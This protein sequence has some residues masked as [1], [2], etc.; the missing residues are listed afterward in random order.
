MLLNGEMTDQFFSRLVLGDKK[1]GAG[2]SKPAL[3]LT[4]AASF[5]CAL[6]ASY[7]IYHVYLLKDMEIPA[8]NKDSIMKKVQEYQL[9]LRTG[10][11][12]FLKEGYTKIADVTAAP[13]DLSQP[14]VVVSEFKPPIDF[15]SKPELLLEPEKLE[16]EP[17]KRKRDKRELITPVLTGNHTIVFRDVGESDASKIRVLAE[18][19]DLKLNII[20]STKKSSRKW[21]VYKENPASKKIVAGKK[22]SFIKSFNKRNDA[23]KYLQNNKIAGLVVSDTTYYDYYDIEVCCLGDEAAEKLARGSGVSMNKV[24]IIKK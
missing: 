5:V 24:K 17:E 10:G 6:F 9:E 7:V 2:T 11:D 3:F 13:E 4:I 14:V 18:N 23:V 19:N 8:L 16:K 22:V 20:G 15:E 1:T 21:Q 12:P